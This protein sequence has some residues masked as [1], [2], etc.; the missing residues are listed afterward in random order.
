MKVITICAFFVLITIINGFFVTLDPESIRAFSEIVHQSQA[1]QQ[2]SLC[3]IVT[4]S[5]IGLSTMWFMFVSV[6]LATVKLE[7]YVRNQSPKNEISE[8]PKIEISE[9]PN[10]VEVNEAP[11]INAKQS[12]LVPVEFIN[13]N[14][15][16]NDYG[17]HDKKCWKTCEDTPKKNEW[18]HTSSPTITNPRMRH[19]IKVCESDFDCSPCAPCSTMCH[20]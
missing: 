20:P 1:A 4:K 17:C 3:K 8:V 11:K 16:N 12:V 14:K 18:C 2:P 9:M 19:H 15:C 10:K 13:N 5:I 7:P 6:N